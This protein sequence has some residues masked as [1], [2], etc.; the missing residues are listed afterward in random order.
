MDNKYCIEI[1]SVLK[2][3]MLYYTISKYVAC[4]TIPILICLTYFYLILLLYFLQFSIQHLLLHFGYL[5]K[6]LLLPTSLLKFCILWKIKNTISN[7]N[8]KDGSMSA[9]H[10][11]CIVLFFGFNVF[12]NLCCHLITF[13][14][15]KLRSKLL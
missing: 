13:E 15:M 4:F 6:R 2:K 5:F 8:H 9:S 10:L 1:I 3:M 12:E 11:L 7:S 14:L